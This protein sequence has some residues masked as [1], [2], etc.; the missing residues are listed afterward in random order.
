MTSELPSQNKVIV[1]GDGRR[2]GKEGEEEKE[3]SCCACVASLC[4]HRLLGLSTRPSL[5]SL[6]LFL[7]SSHQEDETDQEGGGGGGAS[8]GLDDRLEE[9]EK[10][11]RRRNVTNDAQERDELKEKEVE[12][13]VR[14][15][16]SV[17]CRPSDT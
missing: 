13:K 4:S 17:E 9:R 8:K 15:L 11:R 16:H 5:S 7:S 1:A 3:I 10:K 14:R 2:V 12:G 6:C